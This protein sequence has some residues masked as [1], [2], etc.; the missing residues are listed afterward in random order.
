MKYARKMPWCELKDQWNGLSTMNHGS[1]RILSGADGAQS[2]CMTLTEQVLQVMEPLYWYQYC[3]LQDQVFTDHCQLWH[4]SPIASNTDW[5]R[6]FWSAGH[7]SELCVA[8]NLGKTE[9]KIT[10]NSKIPGWLFFMGHV[11]M[12]S[13]KMTITEIDWP[14]LTTENDTNREYD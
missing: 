2:V 1:C 3:R 4:R 14:L 7:R 5:F 9:A 12:S 8:E 6:Q 13:P 10:A 11:V